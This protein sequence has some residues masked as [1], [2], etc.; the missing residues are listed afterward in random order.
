MTTRIR[1]LDLAS[2]LG[3]SIG[4]AFAQEAEA[5]AE[6]G[7]H[8]LVMA[9]GHGNISRGLNASGDRQWT[10]VPTWA[11][12]YNFWLNAHWALGL[13]TDLITETYTVEEFDETVLERTRPVAPAL[14]VTY[15]PHQHWS[16]V[17]GGGMEFAPEENL[18]LMRAGVEY[19]V[20][21]T[22]P[23]ET[24]GAFTYDFRFDAYDSFCVSL[25]IAR[26]F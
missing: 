15:R 2:V 18:G 25:G 19:A 4:T 17:L 7:R 21:L 6:A 20:H 16:F 8:E 11:L 5:E 9:I 22:G 1:F 23:W 10:V 24:T 12:N 13:H 14:M 26:R 3:A